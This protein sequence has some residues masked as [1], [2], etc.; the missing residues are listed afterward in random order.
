[1]VV[2]EASMFSYAEEQCNLKQI[3]MS[4]CRYLLLKD[5]THPLFSV[6]VGYLWNVE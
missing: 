1:M 2:F 5:E 3:P 6:H 4:F